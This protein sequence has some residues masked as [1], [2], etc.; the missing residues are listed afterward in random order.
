MRRILQSPSEELC[1]PHRTDEEVGPRPRRLHL[2]EL[3]RTQGCL[4]PERCSFARLHR[5]LVAPRGRTG[6][7][8]LGSV[9]KVGQ[10]RNALR[11]S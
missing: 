11:P 1:G 4:E 5:T 3:A 8:V 2:E 6:L 10:R 9:S 7:C